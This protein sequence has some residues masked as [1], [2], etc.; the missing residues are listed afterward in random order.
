MRFLKPGAGYVEWR[1][2]LWET[3]HLEITDEQR[4]EVNL[5]SPDSQLPINRTFSN[6]PPN[7]PKPI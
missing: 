2:A 3:L 6:L 5:V 1:S 4:K 7:S